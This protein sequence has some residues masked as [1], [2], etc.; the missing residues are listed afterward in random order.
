M[1]KTFKILPQWRN[2]TEFGHTA[3]YLPAHLSRYVEKRKISEINYQ[4]IR[5]ESSW[6]ERTKHSN[7]S[8]RTE[9]DK[10]EAQ[11]NLKDRIARER[12]EKQRNLKDRI[13]RERKEKQS[14]L[15]DRTARER[16]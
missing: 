3:S 5:A 1:P 9:R 11:R 8:D 14:I 4:E 15:R 6:G 12:K 16:K 13:A 7:L 2:F 10:I